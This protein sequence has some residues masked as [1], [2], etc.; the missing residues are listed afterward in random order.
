[1][2]NVT[3]T[4]KP[5]SVQLA[6]ISVWIVACLAA[7]G[8]AAEAFVTIFGRTPLAFG[9]ADP[10]VQL[11][12]LPQINQAELREGAVGY[13]VDI[14]LWLRVL[15]ATPALLYI[16]MALVAAFLIARVLQEISAGRPFTA[17]VRKNLLALSFLLIGAGLLY[18]T[19]DA[20]ANRAVFEVASNFGTE[21]FPLG[22]DYAV[23][24]TDAPR[25]PY[26]MITSGV[27]G[28]ALS[29]AFKAGGRL[30][31]ETDGLV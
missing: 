18:G 16:V 5:K 2:T 4:R 29:S 27:V 30:Q 24:S 28:L 8:S 23:I 22:A 7:L 3:H 6:V 25:W 12:M 21:G 13:L 10:R 1:M 14:P 19:L 26:F 15:C 9:G 31:E 17:R 11:V 20:T